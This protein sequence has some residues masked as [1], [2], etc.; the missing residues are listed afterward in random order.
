[1]ITYIKQGEVDP[2]ESIN[3]NDINFRMA[4]HVAEGLALTPRMDPRYVKFRL[5]E[6]KT[7]VISND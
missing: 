3:L 2:N 6:Y 7:T 4:V 5:V 1:M